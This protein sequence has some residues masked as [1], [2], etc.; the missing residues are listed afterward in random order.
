MHGKASEC[1][2]PR[3]AGLGPAVSRTSM[4]HPLER[5]VDQG[6]AGELPDVQREGRSGIFP[7][8][9]GPH[10]FGAISAIGASASDSDDLACHEREF[11]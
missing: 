7:L 11:S 2:S 1:A 4:R 8:D 9:I 10:Q 3:S 5:E 6:V